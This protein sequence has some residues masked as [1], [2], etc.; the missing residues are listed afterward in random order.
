MDIWGVDL[1]PLTTQLCV[2]KIPDYLIVS[3]LNIF[4]FQELF[5][6]ISSWCSKQVLLATGRA[7]KSFTLHHEPVSADSGFGFP[8]WHGWGCK[9]PNMVGHGTSIKALQW[10]LDVTLDTKD[11]VSRNIFSF[12]TELHHAHGQLITAG[13]IIRCSL[14]R[15]SSVSSISHTCPFAIRTKELPLGNRQSSKNV[16]IF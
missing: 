16:A 4:K 9:R 1:K 7:Y 6:G 2:Y 3:S 14:L 12:F 15:P 10:W 11:A 8:S 5:W 13:K